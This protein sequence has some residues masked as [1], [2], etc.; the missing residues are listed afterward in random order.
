MGNREPLFLSQLTSERRLLG[1]DLQEELCSPRCHN[2]SKDHI[3]N[4]ET[5]QKAILSAPV[6]VEREGGGMQMDSQLMRTVCRLPSHSC[7]GSPWG[8]VSQHASIHV[9]ATLTAPSA[10]RSYSYPHFTQ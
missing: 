4:G 1:V 2:I 7:S 10:D 5:R 6:F 8:A 3:V 9:L